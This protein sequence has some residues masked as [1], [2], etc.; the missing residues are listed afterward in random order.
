MR[1]SKTISIAV[2]VGILSTAAFA[3][4]DIIKGPYTFEDNAFADF[5][6]KIHDTVPL[7]NACD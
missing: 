4:P 1:S 7:V 2:V 5:A 3:D 6:S